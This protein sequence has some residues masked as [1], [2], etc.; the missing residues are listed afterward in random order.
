M[1]EL[2]GVGPYSGDGR[3]GGDQE[4]VPRPTIQEPRAA[5]DEGIAASERSA[6]QTVL[7][8]GRRE[9]MKKGSNVG[10][11]SVLE[12]GDGLHPRERLP[13][14]EAVCEAEADDAHDPVKTLC[15]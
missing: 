2:Q 11:R 1:K 10:R 12:P 15:V 14:F 5:D 9:S 6:S 8:F 13:G 7:P 3:A 4:G